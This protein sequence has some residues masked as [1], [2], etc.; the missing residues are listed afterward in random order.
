M[1]PN[2]ELTELQLHQFISLL[3]NLAFLRENP[4]F[5]MSKDPAKVKEE[6]VPVLQC[7]QNMLNEYLPRMQT[8]NAA[9]FTQVRHS[10]SASPM[11]CSRVGSCTC[12]PSLPVHTLCVHSPLV[13]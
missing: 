3:I 8:G 9:E 7:A 1:V 6:T 4:R 11:E 5:V 10:L 13:P 2:P 12:T